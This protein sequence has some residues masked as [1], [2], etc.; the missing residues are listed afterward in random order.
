[1]AKFKKL[2]MLCT[3]LMMT[4]SVAAIAACGDEPASSSPDS[5][6]SSVDGSSSSPSDS[7]TPDES[8]TPDDSSSPSDS[9]TPDDSSSSD[10][11]D[12]PAADSTISIAQAIEIGNYLQ[13][14]TEG[15]YYLIGKVA[16]IHAG[17]DGSVY[18][19]NMTIEDR[20]GNKIYVYGTFNA[21]GSTRYGDM[22]PE[23]APQV[24]DNVK[25][26]SVVSYYNGSAQLKNAWIVGSSSYAPPVEE[27]VVAE[28]YW[29]LI[30]SDT[31]SVNAPANEQTW[32][33]L[34]VEVP[35]A[36]K[37][38]IFSFSE[39]GIKFGPEGATD[40]WNECAESYSFEAAEAGTINLSTYVYDWNDINEEVTYYL[41]K[42]DELVLDKEAGVA[43]IAANARTNIKFVAP[44]AGE[45]LIVTNQALTWYGEGLE[46]YGETTTS[47]KVT[48]TEA[49]QEITFEAACSY[50][51]L[52]VTLEWEVVEI[53]PVALVEGD[54]NMTLYAGAYMT[55]SFTSD[56]TG[57]FTF[58][59]ECDYSAYWT[60]NY[61]KSYIG[62]I[63]A[64]ETITL[65]LRYS[66]YTADYEQG[67][68]SIDVVI[69]VA[70]LEEDDPSDLQVG[71]NIFTASEEGVAASFTAPVAGTYAFSDD[72]TNT[73]WFEDTVDYGDSYK[74]I[75]LAEG[76]IVNFTVKYAGLVTL[77][78]EK[79]IPPV[80]LS[81]GENVV[82]IE[83]GATLEWGY[84]VPYNTNLTYSCDNNNVV[85]YVDG[86]ALANGDIFQVSWMSNFEIATADGNNVTGAKITITEYVAPALNDGDNS[87]EAGQYSYTVTNPGC[88]VFTA[89]GDGI[90]SFAVGSQDA[91]DYPD[92][93]SAAGSI[94]I[95]VKPGAT[96]D[97]NIEGEGTM[98]INVACTSTVAM[99][100]GAVTMNDDM[101]APESLTIASLKAGEVAYYAA[102]RMT[103][104]YIVSWSS[105]Y[106][107]VV[108]AGENVG[109][110]YEPQVRLTRTMMDGIVYFVVR[111]SG[112]E[113][114][115]NVV[116]NFAEYVYV[117]PNTQ[118]QGTLVNLNEETTIEIAAWDN[119]IISFVAPAAG[120]YTLTTESSVL[121]DKWV[122]TENWG[123]VW[124][125]AW[126]NYIDS[127]TGGSYSFTLAEGEIINFFVMEFDMGEVS[128]VFTISNEGGSEAPQEPTS[129]GITLQAGVNNNVIL[130]ANT[131]GTAEVYAMGKYTITFPETVTVTFNG[132][133]VAS[134]D[135]IEFANPRLGNPVVVT[136]VDMTV[137]CEAV[138]SLIAYIA[139]P[140]ELD[141]GANAIDVEDTQ[142]GAKATFT[143]TKDG[144]YILKAAD[145]ETNAFVV[146]EN[147]GVS[148][149]LDLPYA[150]SLNAG[151]SITFIVLT[152]NWTP[153]TIDLVVEQDFNL[154]VK[155]AI[156]LGKSYAHNTYTPDKYYI[157][158]TVTGLYNT[159]YGNFYI[160]DDAGNQICIYGLYS[161]DGKTRYDKMAI[162]PVDGDYVKVWG[163]IGSYNSNA[164][165]KNGWLIEHTMPDSSKVN[166]E[167]NGL[168]I[169]T[170]FNNEAEI[171]LPVISTF[172]NEVTLEWDM[173]VSGMGIVTLENGVLTVKNIASDVTV[174]L[175][176]TVTCREESKTKTFI[177]EVSRVEA[178]EPETFT[179]NF[180][181]LSAN[182]SY[183][184][185][186]VNGW[187][188]TNSAILQGGS[189][190]N[191]PTFKSLLGTSSSVKAVCINGKTSAKGTL[192]SPT[193]TS[194]ISKLTF[195]YGYAFSESN[196]V[197]LHVAIK[198]TA[199]TVL[200]ETDVKNT[201]LA[202][203]KAAEYVWALETA[204]E[205]DFVIVFTNNSPSNS[206]SNKDRYAIWNISWTAAA[207]TGGSNVLEADDNVNWAVNVESNKSSVLEGYYIDTTIADVAEGEYTAS[208]STTNEAKVVVYINGKE[209]KN[210]DKLTLSGDVNI[211]VIPTES[212]DFDIN[213]VLSTDE[214][215]KPQEG[216][217][218]DGNWTK[219]Y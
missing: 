173:E 90:T 96:I 110:S 64:G 106:S 201:S 17:K 209:V 115:E 213:F 108:Y 211:V 26:Y 86:A 28:D 139:P 20:S 148:E 29:K 178:G 164:Q 78:V 196:G 5:N 52:Y 154:T 168:N 40:G 54:N 162:K 198:N 39:C 32:G 100:E 179:A 118:P 142:N 53:A 212:K 111:N 203:L 18:Y 24:G 180:S 192:T 206:T 131:Y 147:E 141:L 167:L 181:S 72:Y 189:S 210:D 117:D 79:I 65:E 155:D 6:V 77:L 174:T 107:I 101:T 63:V 87:V 103:G 15:K 89:T 99:L 85:L 47:L 49:G 41:V 159:Q 185:H 169:A 122:Y 133:A 2:A 156:A 73:M 62:S 158:G 149:M 183:G 207:S 69:N 44:A 120:T 36:G 114:L 172:P 105:D 34:S 57:S 197:S 129:V 102:S 161:E 83:A 13:A 92:A 82:N 140:V 37:Y 217:D 46:E 19:G 22:D 194:G 61:E 136:P 76:E 152:S 33:T 119:A 80:T 184:S 166:T 56:K 121:V 43:N 81:L 45:Y 30:G 202:K 51:D 170:K 143:A 113:D 125:R 153:D 91:Y 205:G 112:S 94:A 35:E 165:M 146:M 150:F 171:T 74:E 95:N 25:L 10:V 200:A 3:A 58:S 160:K 188:A 23:L 50:N 157:S 66:G 208:W 16:E 126:E 93:L 67:P 88:Y 204:I 21:D 70:P 199:G 123:G 9:S 1:M 138:I 175:T 216:E 190:D 177:I 75:T 104:D 55:A 215:D 151:E 116:L 191:N 163:I 182:S 135:I 48:A 214:N 128:F 31:I 84:D 134:G 8:S 98:A 193:L 219:N 144:K 137:A 71:E 218:E 132:T 195:N 187:K 60:E 109:M 97:I 27:E 127:A 186:N 124:D 130:E 14:D 4:A 176:A 7:S 11:V 68:G 12:I 42:T 145:G 59:F 38:A